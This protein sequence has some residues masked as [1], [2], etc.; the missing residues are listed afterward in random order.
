[1]SNMNAYNGN[2]Y[3]YWSR[4]FTGTIV[5]NTLLNKFFLENLYK[6]QVLSMK[7]KKLFIRKRLTVWKKI[8][9]LMCMIK[10]LNY[11]L[12]VEVKIM[13]Y[14]YHG[15]SSF[16]IRLHRDSDWIC[17]KITKGNLLKFDMYKDCLSATSMFNMYEGNITGLLFS[18]LEEQLSSRKRDDWTEWDTCDRCFLLFDLLLD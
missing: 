12:Y 2:K 3:S 11:L 10:I 16:F 8:F 6:M 13:F 1:M 5:S 9:S 17:I 18:P 4:N 14:D 15:F 7:S